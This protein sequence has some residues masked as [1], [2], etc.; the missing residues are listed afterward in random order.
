MISE[1]IKEYRKLRGL[2]QVEIAKRL[3]VSQNTVS[4][5]ETGRTEPNMGVIERLS[6]IFECRKSDL[7]GEGGYK[8][9]LTVSELRLITSFRLLSAEQR[10]IIQTPESPAAHVIGPTMP[11]AARPFF[12]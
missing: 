2:S 9:N 1:K 5:W 8:E 3:H 7:I 4:S 10:D 6:Q 11:S 12:L